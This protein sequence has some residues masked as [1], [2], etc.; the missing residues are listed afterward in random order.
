M[1]CGLANVNELLIDVVSA[2]PCCRET[3]GRLCADG[4]AVL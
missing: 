4:L 3:G 1:K 2:G